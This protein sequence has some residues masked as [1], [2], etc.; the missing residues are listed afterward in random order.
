MS[1][2]LKRFLYPNTFFFVLQVVFS[3]KIFLINFFMA[4]T[5]GILIAFISPSIPVWPLPLQPPPT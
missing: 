4:F 2:A 3:I 1:I 5:P